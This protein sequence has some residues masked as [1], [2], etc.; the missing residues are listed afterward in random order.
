MKKSVLR[1][2]LAVSLSATMLLGTGFTAVGQF[3]GTDVSVSAAET[4]Q[5]K[6]YGITGTMTGW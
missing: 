1:K 4:S 5:Q 3:A 6:I 2:A